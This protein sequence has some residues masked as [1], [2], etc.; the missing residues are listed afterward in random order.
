MENNYPTRVPSAVYSRVSTKEQEEGQNIEAHISELLALMEDHGNYLWDKEHG[1]YK[2]QGYSGALLARPHLDRLRDDAKAGRYKVVYFV[3]TDRLARDNHYIGLVINELKELA[4]AC[5][6]KNLPV[7]SGAEGDL[8]L[9]IFGS[10][11]QY[12]RAQIAERFRRGKVHKAKNKKIIVGGPPPYAIRYIKKDPDTRE[13]G[14][15]ELDAA[16]VPVVQ[17]I[18]ELLD[19]EHQ[20]T[21]R[22][23]AK[24]LTEHNIP[25]PKGQKKWARTTVQEIARRS[26]YIGVAYYNKRKAVIPTKRRTTQRYRRQVKTGQRLRPKEEWIPI[27]VPQCSCVPEDQFWRVQKRLEENRAFAKRNRKRRSYLLSGV[28]RCKDPCGSTWFGCSA[29]NPHRV[30][31]YY[32]CTNRLRMHPFPRTC[33]RKMIRADSLDATVWRAL[34]DMAQRPEIVTGHVQKLQKLH[35]DNSAIAER[36][37]LEEKAIEAIAKEEA[38]IFEAYKAGVI[39]L[40]KLQHEQHKIKV[41]KEAHQKMVAALL[42]PKKHGLPHQLVQSTVADYCN[43]IQRK[44]NQ[45]GDD[46]EAKQKLIRSFVRQGIVEDGKVMFNCTI[47]APGVSNRRG[48]PETPERRTEDTPGENKTGTQ[49]KKGVIA[50]TTYQRY[51]HIYTEP[52]IVFKMCIPLNGSEYFLVN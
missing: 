8:M 19:Y 50:A 48:S 52:E 13:D 3:S 36:T 26:E 46:F 9:N 30:T 11:A 37:E 49:E 25:T 27:P 22:Q 34:C 7:A 15:Y 31:P 21:I 20:L 41:K 35:T 51:G 24:W 47:P 10:F 38:R 32:R 5:F 14:Y 4:I 17:K 12:E 18:F 40:D 39:D 2:D 33:H 29:V 6:F 42:P 43:Y 28:L 44:L 1:I 16:Q 45:I 23:V